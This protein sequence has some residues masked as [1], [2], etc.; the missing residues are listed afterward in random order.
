MVSE[1]ETGRGRSTRRISRERRLRRIIGS[2]DQPSARSLRVAG[3][4]TF[5]IR[6]KIF[7]MSRIDQARERR[8]CLVRSLKGFERWEAEH[9]LGQDDEL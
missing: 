5:V 9:G 4:V 6:T 2:F 1:V 8:S 3:S 7:G